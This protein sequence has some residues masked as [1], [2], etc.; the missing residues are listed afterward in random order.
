MRWN[1]VKI[2]LNELAR[3]R[4]IKKM[5]VPKICGVVG[6]SRSIVEVSIRTIRNSGVS[7]MNLTDSEKKSIET[8]IKEEIEKLLREQKNFKLSRV[9]DEF[10]K[11]V[12]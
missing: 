1:N 4:W 9:S 2:D 5:T 11:K 7:Q 10:R 6:K 12:L 3:L 8:A